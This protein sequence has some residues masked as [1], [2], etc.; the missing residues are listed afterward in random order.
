MN[1][2]MSFEEHKKL[3]NDIQKYVADHND[4]EKMLFG[5]QMSI[6]DVIEFSIREALR[7][8]HKPKFIEMNSVVF[9]KLSMELDH[10]L[11]PYEYDLEGE[12]KLYTY[13]GLE[14][15]INEN[16]KDNS[17]EIREMKRE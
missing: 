2:S 7:L 5:N 17:I 8:Y 10:F 11:I 4:I 12:G 9:K 6:I 14:I 3:S 15:V 1:N 16:L 13:K